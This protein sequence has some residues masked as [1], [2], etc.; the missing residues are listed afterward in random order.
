MQNFISN[1]ADQRAAAEKN[2][3]ATIIITYD[4]GVADHASLY[5]QDGANWEIYDPD[6]SY[7][8]KRHAGSGDV[9]SEEN[10]ASRSDWIKFEKD[11]SGSIKIYSFALRSADAKHIENNIDR[12]S[13]SHDNERFLPC[14]HSVSTVLS[15]VGPFKNVT[16]VYLFP[17]ALASQLAKIPHSSQ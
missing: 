11:H 13:D 12:D 6:G 9:V 7:A 2:A 15:G 8:Q 5:V 10:D 3:N 16:P 4:Y 17:S 1:Q 14:A